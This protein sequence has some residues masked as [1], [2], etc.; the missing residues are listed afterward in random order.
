MIRQILFEMCLQAEVACFA[1]KD[2]EFIAFFAEAENSKEVGPE[3]D[4][5]HPNYF[6]STDSA[7]KREESFSKGLYDAVERSDF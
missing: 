1:D 7:D 2:E 3:G 4:D 5:A 6:Q